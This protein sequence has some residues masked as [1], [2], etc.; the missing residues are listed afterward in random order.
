MNDKHDLTADELE[1]AREARRAYD[2]EYRRKNADKVKV[3]NATY[4]ARRAAAQKAQ[5]NGE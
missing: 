3:W 2:R 1:A 5:Q 4:W